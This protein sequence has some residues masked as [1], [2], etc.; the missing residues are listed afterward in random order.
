MVMLSA[1]IFI[2][3]SSV[4]CFLVLNN[5]VVCI[6]VIAITHFI[7]EFFKV[8]YLVLSTFENKN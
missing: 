1:I 7:R 5:S 8:I 3:G 6:S 2:L 4:S